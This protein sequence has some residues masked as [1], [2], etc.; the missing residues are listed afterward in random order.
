MPIDTSRRPGRTLLRA[1]IPALLTLAGIVMLWAPGSAGS[2]HA[3]GE[4]PAGRACVVIL[5]PGGAPDPALTP[6]DEPAGRL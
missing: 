5:H 4:P 3:G 1:A 6:C 2:P